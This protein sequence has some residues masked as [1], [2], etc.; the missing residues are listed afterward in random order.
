METRRG[1]GK[2]DP[3]VYVVPTDESFGTATFSELHEGYIKIHGGSASFEVARLELG[4]VVA[5]LGLGVGMTEKMLNRLHKAERTVE[6][7]EGVLES[8]RVLE[9]SSDRDTALRAMYAA[10]VI[11]G[12]MQEPLELP[13]EPGSGVKALNKSR[14]RGVI[15]FRKFS[16]GRWINPE[17]VPLTDSEMREHYTIVE[18]L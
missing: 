11:R 6:R 5:A 7:L 15:E 9:D 17:V 2:D 18:V 14:P 10:D 1:Y 4:Q 16:D 13:Q 3:K 12:A 8:L